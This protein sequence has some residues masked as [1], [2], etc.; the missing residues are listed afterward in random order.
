MSNQMM[1]AFRKVSMKPGQKLVALV[2]ADHH[3]S[4]T[5]RCDLSHSEIARQAGLSVRSI[6]R[7]LDSLDGKC[8]T[9]HKGNGTKNWYELTPPTHAKTSPVNPCH[10]VTTDDMSLVTSETPTSDIRDIHLYKE[11]NE[12]I[13]EA[14]NDNELTLIADPPAVETKPAKRARKKPP[15]PDP[16]TDPRFHA[17]TSKIGEVCR[18]VTGKPL[19]FNGRFAK[20]LQ[21][22]LKGWNG[23]ADEWLEMYADVLTLSV[24]PFARLTVSASDPAVLCQSWNSVAAEVDKLKADE[25]REQKAGN[26]PIFKGTI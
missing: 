11:S 23:T 5:N 8:L 15:V 4:K 2:L 22:F 19:S 24:R 9:I 20:A 26:K 6:I 14:A 3:N 17:I 21:N 10:G 25:A 13:P 12:S 16:P 7:I 18:S 1:T